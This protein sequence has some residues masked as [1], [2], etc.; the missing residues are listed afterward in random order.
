[1]WWGG[2]VPAIF[3]GSYVPMER[4]FDGTNKENSK[5]QGKNAG[6]KKSLRMWRFPYSMCSPSVGNTLGLPPSCNPILGESTC[7]GTSP[8]I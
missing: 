2:R 6:K 4:F 7:I 8:R 3:L 5:P 1:M